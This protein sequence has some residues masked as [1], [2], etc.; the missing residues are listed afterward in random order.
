MAIAPDG[1]IYVATEGGIYLSRLSDA[2]WELV[3][4]I[5]GYFMQLYSPSGNSVYALERSGAVYKWTEAEGLTQLP[6]P[7][8]DVRVDGRIISIGGRG[9]HE[10]YV[11]GGGGAV[12]RF[13]GE[14]WQA[15]P[16]PLDRFA[17]QPA[18]AV[19][20]G[21]L[22]TIAGN[23]E[24]LVA[25]GSHVVVKRGDEWIEVEDLA[26]RHGFLAAAATPKAV[27]IAGDRSIYS[28]DATVS[29]VADVLTFPTGFIGGIG[30]LE[31]FALFWNSS[32]DLAIL[33]GPSVSTY[34]FTGLDGLRGAVI[35]E[36]AVYIIGVRADTGF[37]AR[38]LP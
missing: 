1:S 11:V 19:Y 18:P 32:R 25:A 14:H 15:E 37:V 24:T 29:H 10:V 12:L 30:Q 7:A 33:S 6:H 28:I 9:T 36:A 5:G 27:L 35:R 4:E 16:N 17:G 26:L 13:D 38:F 3:A 23:D 22:W 31:G 20:E 2:N 34:K 8:S 21:T